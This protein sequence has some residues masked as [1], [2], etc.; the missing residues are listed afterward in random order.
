MPVR[1]WRRGCGPDSRRLSGRTTSSRP[2]ACFPAVAQNRFGSLLFYGPPG[3]GKT[4]LAEVVPRDRQPLCARQRRHVQ[5]GGREDPGRLRGASPSRGPLVYRRAA[6][7]QQVV[8]G[9]PA[10]PMWSRGNVRLIGAT[11]HNPGFYVNPPPLQSHAYLFRLEPLADAAVA[12]VLRA[13]L[14]PTRSAVSAPGSS[15]ARTRVLVGLAVL[16]TVTCAVR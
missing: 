10:C 14:T 6:S 3:C 5:C 8:A 7:V 2:E 11:T 12:G 9:S 13:A 16:A 15:G 1:R 4:S